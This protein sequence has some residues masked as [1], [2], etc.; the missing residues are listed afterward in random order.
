MK[1]IILIALLVLLFILLLK[2]IKNMFKTVVISIAIILIIFAIW[3]F[4]LLESVPQE[5]KQEI[6][7]EPKNETQGNASLSS[8]SNSK[9]KTNIDKI[10]GMFTKEKK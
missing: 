3:K 8:G 9:I 4:D 2:L 5:E 10:T 7:D 6:I 1:L